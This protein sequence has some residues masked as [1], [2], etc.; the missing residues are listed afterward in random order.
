M[1]TDDEP[2]DYFRKLKI[3]EHFCDNDPDIAL[4]VMRGALKDLVVIKGRFK[5]KEGT[6]YGLFIVFIS[7][8]LKK[9]LAQYATVSMDASVYKHKPYEMWKHFLEAISK[10]NREAQLETAKKNTL[11]KVLGRIHELKMFTTIFQLIESNDILTLTNDFNLVLNNSLGADD[12]QTVIDFEYTT[13]INVYE[14]KA[15]APPKD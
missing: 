14:E 3:I 10:E 4:Q 13:S 5:D 8:I 7:T 6:I 15:L 2:R 9:V 1:N 12:I 11:E